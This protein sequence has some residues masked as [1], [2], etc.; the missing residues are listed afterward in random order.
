M[1][2]TALP[3]ERHRERAL[4]LGFQSYVVKPVGADQLLDAVAGLLGLG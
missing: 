4:S 3:G 2:L 1:A